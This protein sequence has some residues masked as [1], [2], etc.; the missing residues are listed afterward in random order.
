MNNF[1]FVELL[2]K[3]ILIDEENQ[4]TINI[5]KIKKSDFESFDS[6]RSCFKIYQ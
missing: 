3:E 2:T 6:H 5:N 1:S 4:K